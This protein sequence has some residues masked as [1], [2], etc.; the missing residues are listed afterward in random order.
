MLSVD[1]NP[2]LLNANRRIPNIFTRF[3]ESMVLYIGL[4]TYSEKPYI[5]TTPQIYIVEIITIS[6]CIIYYSLDF[7]CDGQPIITC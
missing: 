1:E 3:A 4:R 2:M 7:R 5:G 6:I